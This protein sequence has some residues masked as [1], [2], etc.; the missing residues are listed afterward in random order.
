MRRATVLDAVD[1]LN[2]QITLY[3]DDSGWTIRGSPS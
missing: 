2:T 3:T 1:N